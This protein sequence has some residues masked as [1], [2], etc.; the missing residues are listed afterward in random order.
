[1]RWCGKEGISGLL[2]RRK[3]L[4]RTRSRWVQVGRYLARQSEWVQIYRFALNGLLSHILGR[5]PANQLKLQSVLRTA[6]TSL[7]LLS[8]HA[9][10]QARLTRSCR[11][12]LVVVLIQ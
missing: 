6:S 10:A 7:V 12:R 9:D 5:G 3:L 11:N 4:M 8:C 2:A 1:M